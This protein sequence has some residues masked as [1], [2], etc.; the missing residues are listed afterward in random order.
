MLGVYDCV[1]YVDYKIFLGKI[2]YFMVGVWSLEEV[3][4]CVE[5]EWFEIY[6]VFVLIWIIFVL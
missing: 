4:L 5:V 1:D 3:F 2:Y 6:C